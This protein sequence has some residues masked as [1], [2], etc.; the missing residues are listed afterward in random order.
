MRGLL[1]FIRDLEYIFDW[2]NDKKKG[3]TR[4]NHARA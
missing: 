2:S 4:V 3:N 1:K